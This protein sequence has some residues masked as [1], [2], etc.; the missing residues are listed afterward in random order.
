M[1]SY[2]HID[3]HKIDTIIIIIIIKDV[4][5][6]QHSKAD[7]VSCFLMIN[8]WILMRK[9]NLAFLC[10][11]NLFNGIAGNILQTC[12]LIYISGGN[13]RM[14]QGSWN[15]KEKQLCRPE[16]TFKSIFNLIALYFNFLSSSQIHFMELCCYMWMM[17]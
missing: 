11:C 12:L 3:I 15:K 14:L 7:H 2:T 13:A 17:Q 1:C 9:F 10:T 6:P 8:N 4:C 5:T 16:V